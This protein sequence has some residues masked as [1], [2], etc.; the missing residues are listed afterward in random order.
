MN[1]SWN[2]DKLSEEAR[3]YIRAFFERVWVGWTL[4]YMVEV[5]LDDPI[6]HLGDGGDGLIIHG[7]NGSRSYAKHYGDPEW[8]VI[9]CE[10]AAWMAIVETVPTL[11]L[12]DM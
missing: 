11:N 3:S 5:K 8:S 10:D 6:N 7:G 12:V 9:H 4:C 1:D 2:L